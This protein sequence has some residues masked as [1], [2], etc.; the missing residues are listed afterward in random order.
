M[1]RLRGWS[2]RGCP[3]VAKLPHGHG[4]RSPSWQPSAANDSTRRWSSTDHH[5]P[6]LHRFASSS[7]CCPPARQAT[8]WPWTISAATKQG[9][10]PTHSLRRRQAPVPAALLAR[11][12]PNET[13]VRQATPPERRNQVSQ[14]PPKPSNVFQRAAR[15]SASQR[16]QDEDRL[17]LGAGRGCRGELSTRLA[18]SRGA[19]QL[20]EAASAAPSLGAPAC[21]LTMFSAARR[22]RRTS[23]TAS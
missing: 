14:Q 22:A 20:Q 7:S 18:L 23:A 19:A 13:G 10:A 3:L 16:P 6:Q 11:P 8:S 5:R 17:R 1:T 9:G 21:C 15:V 4:G 12:Q 2:R